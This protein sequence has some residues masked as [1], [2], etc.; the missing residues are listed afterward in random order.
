MAF[1]R[2]YKN[3]LMHWMLGVSTSSG[4]SGESMSIATIR[5]WKA[6]NGSIY[7]IYTRDIDFLYSG[8]KDTW[9]TS[10]YANIVN[11]LTYSISDYGLA[12]GTSDAAETIDDYK[13][14]LITT[15]SKTGNLEY[16]TE[17]HADGSYTVYFRGTIVSTQ[18]VTIKEFGLC[19]GWAI[20]S[21]SSA[22]YYP[23]LVFR[24]VLDNPIELLANI[25]AAI[26]FEITYPNI[27]P[28]Y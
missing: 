25:P 8:L 4:S 20:S 28:E 15:I 3:N 7:Y 10:S 9:T 14:N 11:S 26:S 18:N 21:S 2:N 22:T 13:L 5:N 17:P 12:F 19:K 6:M 23:A 16:K 27:M 24:K 1:T